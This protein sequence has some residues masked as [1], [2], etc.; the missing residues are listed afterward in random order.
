[1][2]VTYDHDADALYITLRNAKV[3][4]SSDVSEGVVLDFDETGALVGI[5]VLHASQ[6]MDDPQA[7]HYALTSKAALA[8]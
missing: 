8:R 4:T 2:N 1:M 6:R 3:A 5:E 7:I